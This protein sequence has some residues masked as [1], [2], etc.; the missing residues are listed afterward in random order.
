MDFSLPVGFGFEVLEPLEVIDSNTKGFTLQINSQ[1]TMNL[2][3][4][5]YHAYCIDD[6]IFQ[7]ED[8][9]SV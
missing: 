2:F 7:Y 3:N 8:I 4:L 1:V 6:V 5:T 9:P